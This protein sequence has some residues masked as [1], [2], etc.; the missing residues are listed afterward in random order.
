MVIELRYFREVIAITKLFN[1][2]HIHSCGYLVSMHTLHMH[3]NTHM[4]THTYTHT[5]THAHAHRVETNII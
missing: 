4:Y 3:I 2:T 5:H 1:C